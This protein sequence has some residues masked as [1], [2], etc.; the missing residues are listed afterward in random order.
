[1][2]QAFRDNIDQLGT[3]LNGRF[4]VSSENQHRARP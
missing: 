3:V 4:I 2:N 1:M